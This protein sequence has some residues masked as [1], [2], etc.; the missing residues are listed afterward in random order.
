MPGC[1]AALST[2]NPAEL[3]AL[4]AALPLAPDGT[5]FRYTNAFRCPHCSAPYIDFEAHP[6]YRA[7]EYYGNYFPG[8]P[9]LRYE[10]EP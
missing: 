9:L 10:P 3:A 7:G 1:P 8:T 5:R 6:E 2:P 4:E